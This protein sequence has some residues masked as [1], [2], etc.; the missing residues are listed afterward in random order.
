MKTVLSNRYVDALI[1]TIFFFGITHLIILTLIAV[2]GNI[3]VLN[4]FKILNLDFFIPSLGTGFFNF[5]LSY[6]MV[7][8]VYLPI[9][10]LT[11][12]HLKADR[13]NNQEQE[14]K[15]RALPSWRTWLTKARRNHL[16]ET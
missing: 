11:S 13:Y 5:I 9:Y 14:E 7:A 3:H 4:A 8:A 12:D 16:N 6:C 2:H 10:L 15:N 1:K